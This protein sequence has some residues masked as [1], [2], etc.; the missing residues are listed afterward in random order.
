METKSELFLINKLLSLFRRNKCSSLYFSVTMLLRILT[1]SLTR[2]LSFSLSLC[3]T[4]TH[5]HRPTHTQTL[6]P[7]SVILFLYLSKGQNI[8]NLDV[9][10][11]WHAAPGENSFSDCHLPNKREYQ[12]FTAKIG[13]KRESNLGLLGHQPNRLTTRPPQQ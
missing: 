6:Y 1:H 4:L 7:I 2:A 3:H 8:H 12:A 5:T 11:I 13:G 10:H 9:S